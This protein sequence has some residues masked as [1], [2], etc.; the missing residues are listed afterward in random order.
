MSLSD[1][2]D[3]GEHYGCHTNPDATVHELLNEATEWL[4]YA[5]GVT[6]LLADLVHEADTV[7]CQRM[8]LGLEAIGALTRMGVQCAT[9]AQAK[10]CWERARASG[11]I[12]GGDDLVPPA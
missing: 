10:S 5:R 8:A 9:T 1:I 11:G 12:A 6:G 4:Q 3:V 7:N 2:H